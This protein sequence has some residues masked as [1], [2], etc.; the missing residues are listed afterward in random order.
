MEI[1]IFE[2]A[3]IA[4]IFGGPFLDD[5]FSKPEL[6]VLKLAD[7]LS[8]LI[9]R[10]AFSELIVSE[11]YSLV[12]LITGLLKMLHVVCKLDPN[13]RDLHKYLTF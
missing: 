4:N 5:S 11:L 13:L 12:D 7:F 10:L 3:Q 6:E 9:V 2:L 8:E 1:L